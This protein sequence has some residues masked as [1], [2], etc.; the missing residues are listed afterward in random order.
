MS[1][2]SK[3]PVI[4]GLLT[5]AVLSLPAFSQNVMSVAPAP[6]QANQQE[7]GLTAGDLIGT[8][9][10][11]SRGAEIGEV[12]GVVE[13]GGDIMAVIGFGGFLGF[14]EDRVLVP[15]TELSKQGSDLVAPGYTTDQLRALS[16]RDAKGGEDVPVDTEVSLGAS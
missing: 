8:D 3:T 11:T 15:L 10:L 4:A 7:G 16:R 5:V 9:V 13:V 14:G 6:A 1:Y 12:D 2:R